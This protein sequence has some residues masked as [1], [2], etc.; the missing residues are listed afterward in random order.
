SCKTYDGPT[1]CISAPA[2]SC[3]TAGSNV[4]YCTGANCGGT[5]MPFTSC[6]YSIA[7]GYCFTP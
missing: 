3:F 7:Q 4:M 5:C 6:E 1:G 2:T